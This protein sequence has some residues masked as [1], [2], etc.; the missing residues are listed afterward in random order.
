MSKRFIGLDIHQKIIYATI[1]SV[2]DG[3][4]QQ[5]QLSTQER[6]LNAFLEALKPGDEVALEATRGSNFYVDH[7]SWRVARVAVANPS[8]MRTNKNAKNDRND[9]L[10]LALQ[11]ANGTLP[12]VWVPDQETRQDRELIRHR[13]NTVQEQTRLKNRM[14]ASLAEHGMSWPGSDIQ[15]AG[16]QLFLAKLCNR[17]P[18]VTRQILADQLDRS[19]FLEARL[20]QIEQVIEVRAARW[21]QLALLMTIRGVN[22]L[23]AFTIL[24]T[25]GRIDRFPSADSLAN[26]AGLVP[27]DYSSGGKSRYG[28][29]TKAGSKALRWALTEAV[30]SL[31]R[32][33]G[34]YRN[35][36][37][38]LDRKKKGNGISATA[39]ARKL[40]EA[41]WCMLTRNEKFRLA[42]PELIEEKARRREQ[43]L[44]AALTVAE[45]RKEHQRR[46]LVSQLATLQDLASRGAQMPVP[47][48]LLASFGR[49]LAETG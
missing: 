1:L 36:C 37:R 17:L 23:T 25:I 41:I 22:V 43:R 29:I 18:D 6:D 11:L 2:M 16:A 46:F 19:S 45:A 34:P 40:L 35:L 20:K 4:V 5:Y 39:C 15:S 33:D 21:P 28:G 10:S 3:T 7:I 38:R 48:K 9:S 12:T 32:T 44:K 14:R 47:T 27:R 30:Q 8:R 49:P 13:M 24:A 31:C 42:E 26:Y